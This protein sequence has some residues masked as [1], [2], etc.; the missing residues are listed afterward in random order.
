MNKLHEIDNVLRSQ[1]FS[2]STDIPKII[3]LAATTRLFPDP[4]SVAVFGPSGVGKSYAVEAGLQF[5]PTLEIESISGMSEKALPYL[6][7]EMS[8]KNRVL[9][10][11]EAAGMADGNGRAF[12]RQLMTEGKI[13]YLT[14]QKTSG[15]LKG[16]KLPVVEGP[17][18]FIMTTTANRI[19]HEDQSRLLILNLDYDR[20]TIR[21][22]LLNTANGKTRSAAQ[23]DLT[24]WH[25]LQETL[26]SNPVGVRIPYGER[27]AENMPIE[28][29]KV[30]RD[31]PKVLSM[32]KACALVHQKDRERDEEG[33]ILANRDDYDAI[34]DLL[35]VPLSQGLEADVTPGVRL[36][37]EGTEEIFKI[38]RS[39]SFEGISQSRLAENLNS[40]RSSVLRNVHAAIDL[41]YLVNLNPGKGREAKIKLGERKLSSTEALPCPQVLFE[42]LPLEQVHRCT[43][44]DTE[45]MLTQ[46]PAPWGDEGEWF[47]AG[48]EPKAPE[49]DITW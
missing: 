42:D 43:T 48:T 5:I 32:I 2:G 46:E 4:V 14:V 3:F 7:S 8:L 38:D 41:G 26:K 16:E 19:H 25:E 36:V 33:N 35:S 21:T 1:G 18:C 39:S 37:V 17:I 9:F 28:N 45:P 13:E 22:T 27:L 10:L 47:P 34:Y 24:P 23:I 49:Q 44:S 12:L 11:G 30:Q 15:G 31:F 40:D 29:I 6:G 20:D